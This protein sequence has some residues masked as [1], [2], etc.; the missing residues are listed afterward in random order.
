MLT[1]WC[2]RS[3]ETGG[4]LSESLRPEAPLLAR[5]L[6]VILR[7]KDM[8]LVGE[9]RVC[10]AATGHGRGVPARVRVRTRSATA[11]ITYQVAQASLIQPLQDGATFVR[12][13]HCH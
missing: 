1:D 3:L 11:S 2:A 10:L 5:R 9:M 8:E 12:Q 4:G 7:C 6:P 13:G